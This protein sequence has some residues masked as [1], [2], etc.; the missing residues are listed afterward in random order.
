[1]PTLSTTNW[2]TTVTEEGKIYKEFPF[3]IKIGDVFYS[4]FGADEKFTLKNEEKKD[5]GKITVGNLG[6]LSFCEGEDE[7]AVLITTDLEED[8]S[9]D[10]DK[11][12]VETSYMLHLIANIDETGTVTFKLNDFISTVEGVTAKIL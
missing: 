9:V 1:M 10:I 7:N 11:N 8:H 12:G 5:I 4:G 6:I 2:I 3:L